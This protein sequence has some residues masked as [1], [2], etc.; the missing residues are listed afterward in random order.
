MEFSRYVFIVYFF[1]LLQQKMQQQ[2]R[3]K[4]VERDEIERLRK[5]WN[6]NRF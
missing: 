6:T 3:L 5:N 2:K 4:K 1:K